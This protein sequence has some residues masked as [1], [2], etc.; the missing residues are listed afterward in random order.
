M[1]VI[2]LALLAHMTQLLASLPN[3]P[4]APRE[5]FRTPPARDCRYVLDLLQV[6][7]TSEY[8]LLQI[9]N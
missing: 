6:G 8:S 4:T 7:Q 5:D 1:I 2:R 9:L 3:F